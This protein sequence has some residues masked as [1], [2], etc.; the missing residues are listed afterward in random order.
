[1]N[2]N[3]AAEM[4]SNGS[5]MLEIGNHFGIS[6]GAVAGI[7]SRNR[8][9]FPTKP[10]PTKKPK[11]KHEALASPEY[12]EPMKVLGSVLIADKVVTPLR[13]QYMGAREIKKYADRLSSAYEEATGEEY[14]GSDIKE[15]YVMMDEERK[16]TKRRSA[17]VTRKMFHEAYQPATP[18]KPNLTAKEYDQSRLP[19]YTLWELDARGCKWPLLETVRGET[20]MFCGETR[21]Q[22]KPWCEH[23]HKRAWRAS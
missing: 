22:M 21:Y 18:P 13:R 19:G 12:T 15:I 2:I 10:K 14:K 7:I 16:S 3:V 1:M 9:W 6:R 23:H 20:Q 4:W 5:T 11:Q 17:D 8:E